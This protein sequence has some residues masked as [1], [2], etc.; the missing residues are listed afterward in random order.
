MKVLDDGCVRHTMRLIG[1]WARVFLTV[2]SGKRGGGPGGR[3]G[4]VIDL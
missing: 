4:G 1:S 3:M 2:I